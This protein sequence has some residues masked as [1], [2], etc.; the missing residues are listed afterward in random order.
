M[1][2]MSITGMSEAE[3]F[4]EREAEYF[5]FTP[6][7]LLDEIGEIVVKTVFGMFDG[8]E[9]A[10]HGAVGSFLNRGQLQ[11]VSLWL[12]DETTNCGCSTG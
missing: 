11:A 2:A 12:N 5:G 3:F 6:F 7:Q 9:Q 4:Y 1:S 8:V 10:L